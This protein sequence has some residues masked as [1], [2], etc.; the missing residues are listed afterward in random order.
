MTFRDATE[1]SVG[2]NEGERPSCS[3]FTY[4]C[5]GGGMVDTVVLEATVERRGSSSLPWGT[6]LKHIDV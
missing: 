4:E 5:P 2:S 6:I 3:V 1:C